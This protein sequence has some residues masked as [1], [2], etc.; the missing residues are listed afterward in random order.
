[1]PR[2][3]TISFTPQQDDVIRKCW[4]HNVYGHHA[5]KRAAQLTGFSP[6][7]VHRR[8]TQLGLVFTRERY[9][10]TEPELKIVEEHAHLALDTI[11]K[12]LRLVSPPGVKRTRAAIAGQIHTQR[13][14][15]N[16]DGLKHGPLADALGISCDSLHRFRERDLIKGQRLESLRDACGYG[17]VRQAVQVDAAVRIRRGRPPKWP[18]AEEG[19]HPSRRSRNADAYVEQ[20]PDEHRHWFY[21]NDEIVR[22]L[23]AAPGELDLRKVNQIW[24]MGL[25]EP[26]ITIFQPTRKELLETERERTKLAHRRSRKTTRSTSTRLR[27]PGILGEVVVD[28]IRAGKSTLTR[29]GRPSGSAGHSNGDPGSPL[30]N[31]DIGMRLR[32]SADASASLKS[33]RDAE[34]SHSDSRCSGS[35]GDLSAV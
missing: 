25:L 28:A 22:L 12:K 11:Q 33:G 10:W 8:A 30:S 3:Q 13:F 7:A 24:L 29:T 9:R 26:Y 20:A 21:P 15:T 17:P 31:T 5:A 19:R 1:M 2:G 32:L 27:K 6:D 23:F 14:R 34:R 16:M 4:A 35:A 18:R